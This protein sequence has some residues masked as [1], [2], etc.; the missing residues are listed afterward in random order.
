MLLTLLPVHAGDPLHVP[1]A[2]VGADDGGHA[3]AEVDVPGGQLDGGHTA[4]E[5]DVL[6]GQA[7]AACA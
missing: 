6:G 4:A 1:Q 3:A 7:G 5:V 2:S